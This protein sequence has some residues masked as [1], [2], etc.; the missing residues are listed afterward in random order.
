MIKISVPL[1]HKG[2]EILIGENIMKEL[3]RI[4]QLGNYEKV[5]V[6]SDE[7][8][9]GLHGDTL[10]SA[11]KEAAIPFT[12]QIIPPGEEAKN[13]SMLEHLYESFSE[14]HLDRN[15][16]IIAFGG[17]VIGDLAGF[18]AA[19]WMRG[20]DFIQIPTTLLAQVDSAIGG[21]TAINMKSGKNLIGAFHQPRLVLSEM[22]F[23]KTLPSRE[24]KCGIAEMVKYGAILSKKMI[25]L[26]KEPIDK[27][28]LPHLIADCCSLKSHV[29]TEDEKDKGRRMI[30]NFGHT[31]GHAV[32]KLGNYSRYNHGE[33]VAI[34]MVIAAAFGEKTGITKKGCRD[35]IKQILS[36]QGI[37]S[38]CPYSFKQIGDAMAGDKKSRGKGI[39]LILLQDI[40]EATI[41]NY[42][43]ELI[44][45][46]LSE[47]I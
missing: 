26:L 32:E 43:L 3:S 46:T 35:Y 15:D 8:I 20:L 7:N 23:L 18:A 34:G 42:P 22:S 14:A 11:L 27:L 39:D 6:V 16:L 21:K 31:F 29:V 30:L 5:I 44:K 45:Q 1:T 41:V 47:V 33:A 25:D 37:E 12:S 36:A 10:S 9:W 28:S 38:H 40:G 19:T 24:I 4:S 17:G 13:L 2:Y